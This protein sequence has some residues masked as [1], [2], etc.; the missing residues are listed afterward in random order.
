VGLGESLSEWEVAKLTDW[1]DQLVVLALLALAVAAVVA[2][3]VPA[4]TL[5]LGVLLSY[6]AL[7]DFLIAIDDVANG[8]TL[9]AADVMGFV[10]GLVAT[11]TSVFL[12]ANALPADE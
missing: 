6:F 1:V 8:G 3:R 7:P 10:S 5:V 2:R 11:G 12:I 4:L 9:F